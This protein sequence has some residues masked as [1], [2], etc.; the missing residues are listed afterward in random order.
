M[1]RLP[2]LDGLRGAA[3][4]AVVIA[5]YFGEVDHG[6][7][8]LSFGWLGVGVFFALSG[9]LIGSIILEGHGR[10]GFLQ[11]FYFRRA[12]RI[13]PIYLVVVLGAL[14]AI[15][16]L[17]RHAWATPAFGLPT[18]LTFTQNFSVA[19]Q[20]VGNAWLLP[21][22][23]LAVEEQFYILLPLLIMVLPSRALIWV[24]AGIML[25]AVAF[26]LA[27]FDSNNLAAMVLLPAKAD[28]LL[29]GVI[30]AWLQRRVDLTRYLLALRVIPLVTVWAL[31]AVSLADPSK[32]LFT[33]ASPL[34]LGLGA[35]S[36]ILAIVLGAPE[37]KRFEVPWLGFFGTISYALYLVHQPINGLLQGLLL[38]GKPDVAPLPALLVTAVAMVLSIAVAYGSW[39]LLERP[40]LGWARRSSRLRSS[41]PGEPPRIAMGGAAVGGI[42]VL[43][44]DAD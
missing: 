2:Q 24:L 19:F 5:H 7:R 27:V 9:Y 33:I 17:R 13:I 41:D 1:K 26:R 25:A 44:T 18:Y 3:A 22:W 14:L 43:R 32:R 34:L 29:G 11:Q 38:G 10:P 21:T 12:V 23:T 15:G 42:P 30:A 37:A 8:A 4:L 40:L 16:I 20:R 36:F 31:L 6:A 35:P 39:V 28:L